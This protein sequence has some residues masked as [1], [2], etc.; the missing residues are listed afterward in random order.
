MNQAFFS[1]PLSRYTTM[2]LIFALV[3]FAFLMGAKANDRCPSSEDHQLSA[4]RY[5]MFTAYQ[6][7]FDGYQAPCQIK[8][9]EK[10]TCV[11]QCQQQ[12]A[13]SSLAEHMD[14]ELKQRGLA[15]C[16]SLSQICLEEC[17]GDSNHCQKACQKKTL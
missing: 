10:E 16:E 8:C 13:L 2:S 5:Q 12:K 1:R 9:F 15:R 11:N 14:Q 4:V 3:T 7:A 17:Q 6:V